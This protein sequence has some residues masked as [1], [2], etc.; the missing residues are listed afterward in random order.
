MT[1]KKEKDEFGLK[2]ER[3]EKLKAA[4]PSSSKTKKVENWTPELAQ[5]LADV[6]AERDA[7]AAR[8]Q[9]IENAPFQVPAQIGSMAA[10]DRFLLAE[11]K[12]FL[13]E[14]LRT[15]QFNSSIASELLKR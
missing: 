14:C 11:L 10:P 6:M 12:S 4:K 3:L 13:G 9:E 1:K 8:V 2:E 5:A 15:G 7:L